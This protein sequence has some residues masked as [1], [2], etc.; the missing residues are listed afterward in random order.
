MF[1]VYSPE[2][3]N[4]IPSGK[5]LPDLKA[6]RVKQ[7]LA[8][9][10][11]EM[12]Q[13]HLDIQHPYGK[14]KPKVHNALEQYHQVQ[15]PHD[16]VVVVKAQ[17]IMSQPVVR[18]T[19]ESSLDEAWLLMQKSRI[20][21][22]PVETPTGQLV[23]VVTSTEILARVIVNQKGDIEQ[24]MPEAVSDVMIEEVITTKGETDIRRVALVMS[25]YSISCL[26]IMSETEEVIGIVTLSDIVKRLSELPPLE[27]Y[28]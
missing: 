27:I 9:G 5:N 21:H 13:F 11:S 4:Y 22:L 3:R 14:Q 1:V 24:S 16:R 20:H 10:E 26:P 7:V 23:G 6:D 19:P 15:S 8:E 2:G 28:A 17:E 18:I 25:A 12:D